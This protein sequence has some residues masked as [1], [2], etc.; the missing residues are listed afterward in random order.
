MTKARQLEHEIFD[1]EMLKILSWVNIA[2]SFEVILIFA[3]LSSAILRIV[4]PPRPVDMKGSRKERRDREGKIEE[5]FAEMEQMKTRGGDNEIDGKIRKI[6]GGK[7][8]ARG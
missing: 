1:P 5:E 4:K 3:P 6:N 2:S 8:A 7:G